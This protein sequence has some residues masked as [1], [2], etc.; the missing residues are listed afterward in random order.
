MIIPRSFRICWL[1]L[2]VLVPLRGFALEAYL[3]PDRAFEGDIVKLVLHYE[4]DI[5]S[6]YAL[7]TSPLERDFEVIDAQSRVHRLHDSELPALR[8]EWTVLIAPRKSGT[9]EVPPMRLGQ[10]V[11]DSLWLEVEPRSKSERDKND[12]ALEMEVSTA[13]PYIGQQVIVTMRLLS[14][15]TLKNARIM[16]PETGQGRVYRNRKDRY[17]SVTRE[18]RQYDVLERNLSL[19]VDRAGSLD[20]GVASF[21][22]GLVNQPLRQ[23]LRKSDPVE[24]QIRPRPDEYADQVWLPAETLEISQRW[25]MPDRQLEV[26]QSLGLTLTIE[27]RGLAAE[28]LPVD[29]ASLDGSTFRIY[30]DEA[31]FTN[32]FDGAS[33][34]GKLEQSFV[35][36]ASSAGMIEVPPLSLHWWDTHSNSLREIILPGRQLDAV[37]SAA[38]L[39]SP[40]PADQALPG[41]EAGQ[42]STTTAWIWIGLTFLLVGILLPP[43]SRSPAFRVLSGF[44]R[45][46]ETRD[47]EQHFKAACLANDPGLARSG[48]I[49]LARQYWPEENIH[50]LQAIADRLVDEEFS[51]QLG[52]LDA[53][54][55]AR[56][57]NAWTGEALWRAFA[58]SRRSRAVNRRR[59]PSALPRLY[60]E[61]FRRRLSPNP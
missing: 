50:G 61:A 6:L 38:S 10:H 52:Q 37:G 31:Q 47:C 28:S 57:S 46:R 24:L 59:S 54:I 40:V 30:P 16:E 5:A 58:G 48:L 12:I 8:M 14:N 33:V 7:D 51:L 35:F 45:Y 13:S 32:S 34:V 42:S 15:T 21:W 23:I 22:G 2:L 44:R 18:G 4:N 36:V 56:R 39:A 43:G 27:A 25:E 19:F 29:L 11:S 9:I 53:A 55:Y 49:T 60:P 20:L 3:Q 1:M 41:F 26:G 17:F